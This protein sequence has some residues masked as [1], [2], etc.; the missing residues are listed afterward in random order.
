MGAQKKIPPT[1]PGEII[2]VDFLE[3]LGLSQKKLAD[4]LGV[5]PRRIS[6]IINAKGR[7]TGE[8][9]LRLAHFFDMTPRFWLGIQARYDLDVAEEALEGRIEREVKTKEEVLAA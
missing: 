3:P 9:A 8:I 1:H 7:I 6:N 5:S 2:K 4:A